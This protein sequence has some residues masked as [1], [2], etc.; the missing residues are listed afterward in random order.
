[1]QLASCTEGLILIKCRGFVHEGLLLQSWTQLNSVGPWLFQFVFCA[2]PQGWVPWSYIKSCVLW[3]PA[4]S[5]LS[6]VS[7][8]TP[9]S[10]IWL[11][12]KD[13]NIWAGN[14]LTGVGLLLVLTD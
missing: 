2:G 14:Y 7:R 5:V 4:C 9:R 8:R 10:Q 1:M 11:P 3:V 12:R 6:S 13:L